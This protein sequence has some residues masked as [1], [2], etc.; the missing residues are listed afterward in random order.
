MVSAGSGKG[1]EVVPWL[2]AG[3]RDPG[4]VRVRGLLSSAT[5]SHPA[6]GHDRQSAGQDLHIGVRLAGEGCRHGTSSG[7][8]QPQ[9]RVGCKRQD[10]CFEQQL[11]D[12]AGSW[13]WLVRS[14]SCSSA[15]SLASSGSAHRRTRR[16]SRS[17]CCATS[18]LCCAARWQGRGAPLP[19]E[20]SCPAW[21]AFSAGNAGYLIGDAGHPA[22]LAPRPGGPVLDLPL[23]APPKHA[24]LSTKRSSPWSC[25]WPGRTGAGAISGSSAS[26]ESS[27]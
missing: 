4:H 22:A 15:G 21:P 3:R 26:A 18:S 19:T 25:A 20:R 10:L 5:G 14:R 9:K 23:V 24:T 1:S 6:D 17:P 11:R 12:L 13:A 2:T 7:I 16:T 8:S 27:A